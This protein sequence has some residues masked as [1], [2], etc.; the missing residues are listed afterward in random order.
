VATIAQSKT[1]NKIIFSILLLIAMFIIGVVGFTVISD[2][3]TMGDAVWIT[4][5]ILSTVG[6]TNLVLDPNERIWASILM[7][8]GVLTVFYVG[9]NL[10][11]FIVDGEL[12]HMFGRRHVEKQISQL[13]NHTIVCGYGR[14]GE[15]LCDRLAAQGQPFVAIDSD[16]DKKDQ[17]DAKGYLFIQ[18]D[19]MSEQTLNDAQVHRAMGLASCLHSD[20]D[21][22][23]VTLTARELNEDLI[24]IARSEN[25]E[26]EGKLKRAGVSRVICTPEHS[27][28]KAMQML[29]HPA[30]EEL[31]ELAVSGDDLEVTKVQVVQLPKIF[32]KTLRELALPKITGY[33]VVAMVRP[34]GSRSFN[35]PP[36]TKLDAGDELIVIGPTGG[37]TK[38]FDAYGPENG[39]LG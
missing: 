2:K 26:T 32:G 30:V 17:A 4:I 28:S 20:A 1:R 37:I 27:A 34:D 35:P 21:N 12:R 6:A 13:K 3:H 9:G 15:A 14:M 25:K 31:V 19:A 36:D 5:N 10:V 16:G 8:G 33:I 22:V 11:A 39:H 24:I 38:L 7:V 23:F 29:M 18:G